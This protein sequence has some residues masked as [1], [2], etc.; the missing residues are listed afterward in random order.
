M[1]DS[2]VHSVSATVHCSSNQ[3]PNSSAPKPPPSEAS[4]VYRPCSPRPISA[5]PPPLPPTACSMPS[6]VCTSLGTSM[7]PTSLV[8]AGVVP[9]RSKPPFVPLPRKDD[10]AQMLKPKMQTQ[11]YEYEHYM[12]STKS[13]DARNGFYLRFY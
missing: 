11:S 6:P 10:Y 4:N 3:A 9:D 2:T 1:Y 13:E 12:T 8:Q 5:A 7:Q